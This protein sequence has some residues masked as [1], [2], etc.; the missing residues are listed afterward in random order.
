MMRT[1]GF[2][3][4]ALL[5]IACGDER[6]TDGAPPA[7]GRPA[8]CGVAHD[9]VSDLFC[10]PKAAEIE[11]L[12]ELQS[13]LEL[14]RTLF[15]AHSTAL[16]G[17][18]ASSI[19][20]RAVLLR[21]NGFAEG[22]V[23]LTFTRGEQR[24]ELVSLD[25]KAE[26]FN[27]YLLDFS[28]ACN[29][30]P[31]GCTHGDLFTP[32]IESGWRDLRVRDDEELK[33]TP[34]DCRR[35]HGGA[36]HEGGKPM[37]LMREADPPWM[38][39][40]PLP[41][42]ETSPLLADLLAAKGA[43]PYAG[44][45]APFDPSLLE[46]QVRE[47]ARAQL[48]PRQPLDF[49][50]GIIAVETKQPVTP[51]DY[52]APHDED[53][54]H[55]SPTWQLLYDDYLEGFALPPPYHAERATD[56]DK[57]AAAT[58]A[59]RDF[60]EGR[61]E[62]DELPDIGDV[63]PDD[64]LALAYRSFAVLPDARGEAL[65]NQ[66]C[67]PC[68]NASLDPTISRA[69]FDADL[70][71]VSRGALE[72][73]RARL[74]L[75]AEDPSAMPPPGTLL[76]S[77]AQRRE[78]REYL[79]KIDPEELTPR[80][81]RGYASSDYALERGFHYEGELGAGA[82]AIGDLN[83]DGRLDVATGSLVFEQRADGTLAE[84]RPLPAKSSG[85]IALVDV[86][87]D[88]RLDLIAHGVGLEPERGL[89]TYLAEGDLRFS[90]P[91]ASEGPSAADLVSGNFVDVDRDGELDLVT[92]TLPS[93]SRVVVYLGDGA[94]GFR[95]QEVERSDAGDTRLSA[96]VLGDM[97]GDELPDLIVSDA[98]LKYAVTIHAHD[99]A[100]GFEP[101]GTRYAIPE[102]VAFDLFLAVGDGNADARNDLVISPGIRLM[103]RDADGAFGP[104]PMLENNEGPTTLSDIDADGR[105]DLVAFAQNVG[106]IRVLLQGERGLHRAR[107]VAFEL[108]DA[109]GSVRDTFEVRD[110]SSD[111]CPDVAVSR[112]GSIT[113]LYGS[114]CEP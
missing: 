43:E 109:P 5:L 80:H 7:P 100:G 45:T 46:E 88:G 111:G 48:Q 67:G 110:L 13:A 65:V 56:P 105:S 61:I 37:L 93:L 34:L 54:E 87:R 75:D 76:M 14:D 94:G 79:G 11:S 44:A 104:A 63:L 73:A 69:R 55:H 21:E 77:A 84:P 72:L 40:F 82:M 18:L 51:F 31:G 95:A 29:E 89:V 12:S 22:Y 96:I 103:L 107:S 78:L 99:G 102:T 33:N 60:V 59:Y 26:R 27:F 30:E 49:L 113:V 23:A 81:A 86:D 70:S 91:I 90:D 68:H 114:G 108:P 62:Q 38:H 20:P 74:A 9:E 2:A 17:R 101:E 3:A 24:A 71:Q 52:V 66:A 4:L 1:P 106:E 19:N 64:Q 83:D 58:A 50:S 98:P 16:G 85:P 41:D 53:V 28:Q 97:T 112:R 35:C 42:R 32:A 47:A 15:L 25:R 10:G 39:W 6:Q 36:P 57:L 8:F 92:R